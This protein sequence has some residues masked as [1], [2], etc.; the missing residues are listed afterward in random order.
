MELGAPRH[1]GRT[2]RFSVSSA[3]KL[4]GM[5]ITTLREHV[6][7]NQGY[8]DP[9]DLLKIRVRMRALD[10]ALATNTLRAAADLMV[11]L[12][13]AAKLMR[14]QP[15]QRDEVYAAKHRLLRALAAHGYL[16]GVGEHTIT[17]GCY[18]CDGSGVYR[19]YA[20]DREDCERCC[21]TGIS[22]T[23]YRVLRY[24]VEDRSY[25][26]HEPPRDATWPL[27]EGVPNVD[28]GDD[29]HPGVH[30]PVLLAPE[31]WATAVAHVTR[32]CDAFDPLDAEP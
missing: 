20:G 8:I 12:N 10:I 6:S 25:T 27:P 16:I 1:G 30:R 11:E 2:A 18:G 15:C 3:S 7:V 5:S 14:V 32:V 19:G 29:W 13:R 26:W 31:H 4:L 9:R 23:R 21:G 24:Q 17:Q 28:V 22:K